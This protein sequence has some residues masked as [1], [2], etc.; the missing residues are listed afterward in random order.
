MITGKNKIETIIER[1]RE[2]GFD[3]AAVTA[4]VLPDADRKNYETWC[5]SGYAGG[6]TYMT[7]NP[8]ERVDIART[9]PGVQSVL[10][11]GV[12]YYQGPLPEKPGPGYG[13]VARYAWGLDYHTVIVERL[14]TF[15]AEL[16]IKAA[17]AV[18]SKPLLERAL[19]KQAGLGFVGKNT[20]LIIPTFHVG[21]FVFLTELLL[22][23]PLE[24]FGGSLQE[25]R[26]A[27]SGCGGCS[28]C[29]TACPTGAF[30]S[31]YTLNAN[32]CIAY[33][34]IEN[35]GAVPREMRPPMGDW[36]FG[37]DVCQDVCPFNARAK[38]TQW[39]EFN[40]DRGVG[41]WI[42]LREILDIPDPSAFKNKW[43]KTPLS[44]AKRQGMIRNACVAAGNSGQESMVPLLRNCAAD[45]NPMIRGHAVWALSRLCSG[46]RAVRW[47][48][49]RLRQE[50]DPTVIEELKNF[51]L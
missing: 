41:P 39:P 6:M 49:E 27:L 44:R 26:T 47:A 45:D 38:E 3:H 46:S 25:P 9:Y 33:L 12:S 43:G 34:T 18:D 37:C 29:L 48:Q 28:R 14:R 50:S 16:D 15:L 21:S 11:L 31:P 17:I 40:A 42:S 22:D 24:E 13:R 4:P 36:V 5:L 30:E 7:R 10:T 2:F 20:V 51:V 35:K 19:A 8:S 32:K 1:A 23:I